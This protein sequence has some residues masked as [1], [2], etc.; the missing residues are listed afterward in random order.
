MWRM[1]GWKSKYAAASSTLMAST[2]AMLFPRKRTASVS[3]E[4]RAPPH[5][6]QATVTSGRKLISMV[7]EPWPSH[8]SHRPPFTL[9][10]NRLAV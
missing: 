6:S 5:A 3:A 10:E 2:S 4:N 9:N 8:S 7:R 1:P